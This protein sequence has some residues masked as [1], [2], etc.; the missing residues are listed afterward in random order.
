MFTHS[1]FK[2]VPSFAII[3]STVAIAL[4]FINNASK[5]ENR[6]FIFEYEEIDQLASTL[7]YNSKIA[8][9]EFIFHYKTNS[10][11][12]LKRKFTKI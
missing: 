10:N 6:N 7:E 3:G 11:A 2:M 1:D 5:Q 4:K 12:N 8:V 9:G